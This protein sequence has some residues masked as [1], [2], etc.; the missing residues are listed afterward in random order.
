[1]TLNPF[2]RKYNPA[3]TLATLAKLGRRASRWT[4]EPDLGDRTFPL[5]IMTGPEKES[6]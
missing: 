4:Q 3:D 5:I 2:R 1:M 6:K